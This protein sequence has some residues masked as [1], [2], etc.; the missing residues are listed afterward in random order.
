MNLLRTTALA[1]TL[2]AAAGPVFLAGPAQASL[3]ILSSVGGAPTGVNTWNL[4]VGVATP[5]DI[6]SIQFTGSAGFVTGNRGGRYAAPFLSGNNGAGFGP[7][8]GNQPTGQ[9][10]TQYLTT[11]STNERGGAGVTINFVHD[12]QYLGLLWGSVD[13]YNI[14]RFYDGTTLVGQLTGSSV[15]PQATG[16]QGANG[17]FYVNINSTVAFDRVEFTSNGYAFE[18]DNLAW[19]RQAVSEPPA[20]A[21]LGMALVGLG[22]ALRLRRPA[23]TA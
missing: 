1:V 3:S 15:T 21:L 8:G 17:T 22:I 23:Q 12:Q 20:L 18:F 5:D 6:A 14:L 7:S 13:A 19:N 2:A 11:G 9:D 10:T 16:N 4:D